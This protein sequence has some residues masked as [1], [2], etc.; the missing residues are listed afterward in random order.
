MDTNEAMAVVT[1]IS[2]GLG[3]GDSASR[4]SKASVTAAVPMTFT[5]RRVFRAVGRGTPGMSA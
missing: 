2:L 4:G 1:K 3:E 5:S